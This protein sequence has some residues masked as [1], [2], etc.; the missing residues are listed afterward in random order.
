MVICLCSDGCIYACTYNAFHHSCLTSCA[1]TNQL[2]ILINLSTTHCSTRDMLRKLID[3][4]SQDWVFMCSYL[5]F[6]V[7]FHLLATLVPQ[8]FSG[9]VCDWTKARQSWFIVYNCQGFFKEAC[10]WEVIFHFSISFW[11]AL[12]MLRCHWDNNLMSQPNTE[13]ACMH[14]FTTFTTFHYRISY[15]YIRQI[16]QLWVL[17]ICNWGEW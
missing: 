5:C 9:L 6:L 12:F 4:H 3:G 15:C 16:W 2:F 1:L 14:T 7:I 10:G 13:H 17:Q 11:L 8:S